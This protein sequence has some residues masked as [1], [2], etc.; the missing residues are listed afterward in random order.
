MLTAAVR[1]LHLAHRGKFETDVRTSVDALW[2]NNPFITRLSEGETG[3]EYIEM[4]YPLVHESNQRPYHFLH[5]YPQYLEQQLGVKIPLT[6][7]AGDTRSRLQLPTAFPNPKT[8]IFNRILP[9]YRVIV[10]TDDRS[11]FS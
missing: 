5:G 4:H 9:R 1:D 11:T 8:Q 7:F 6:R 2:L 3:V 10:A